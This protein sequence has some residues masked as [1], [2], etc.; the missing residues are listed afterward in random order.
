MNLL[1]PRALQPGDTLGIVACSTSI[2]ASSA[3]T[4]ERTYRRLSERG[5]KIIEASNVRKIHGHSA[6]TIRE[7][8]EAIHGFFE[9]PGISG[10]LNFWGGFQS[11]QLL[12]HLD[13]ELIRAN[14]KAFVGFSDTTV[15]QAALYSKAGLV[16]FSGPA[17]I[18]FGKPVLP[19]F[20][21]E[22]FEKV[23][24]R[25]EVPLRL[26]ASDQYSDNPWF[27]EQ[28]Q[29]M[30]FETNPGWRVYR[31]GKAEGPIVGGN[32]GTL[33]LLAG[34]SFW[35]DMRGKILFVEDDEAENPK[36]MDRLF[37]QLRQM[38]VYDQIAGLVVGRFHRAVKFNESDSLEMIFDDALAGYEFPVVTGVDFGHTDPLITIPIGVRC[39]MDTQGPR[40]EFLE[41]AVT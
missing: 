3:E 15:L 21:W 32:L 1:K 10:I 30:C 34:T 38:G 4:I 33:L 31:E 19:D 22:H 40:I 8:V 41:S 14:P 7:R 5:F 16:T 24:I 13:F 35:P 23:L 12:E 9:D 37:T 39:G 36:T 26:R 25:P 18:T 20:T 29:Q 17:G 11:H 28:D 27:M 6:G 2:T